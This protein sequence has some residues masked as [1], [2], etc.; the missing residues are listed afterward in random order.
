[1]KRYLINNSLISTIKKSRHSLRDIN[2]KLDFEIRNALYKNKTLSYEQLE[3]LEALFNK[4][5][6]LKIIY[7]N[8][9][10]NLGKKVF[11]KPIQQPNKT[12]KLAE[13]IGIML[14]DGNLWK[15]RIKIAFDKRNKEYLNYVSSLFFNIFGIKLNKEIH[16]GTNQAYLHC[17]NLYIVEELIKQGLKRGH[18]IKNNI[19]IPIWIKEN[20]NYAKACIR[21]LID[22]DGCIYV[23]K[24]EKQTYIKFTNFNKQ[25]LKDFKELTVILGYHFAKANKNNWCL[26]RKEEVAKLFNDIKPIKSS[27]AVGKPG[28]L[29]GLG[30][31][32]LGSNPSSPI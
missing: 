30:P 6:R 26:Y 7:I 32:V 17:T 31:D 4:K 1:M 23:C 12:I 5:F 13:F 2:K 11:T 25:L 14:G 3:K 21:G 20:K 22:T 27:G 8:Y 19:G 16:N 9:G 10:R 18:K 15:N 24:R 28:I 29:S